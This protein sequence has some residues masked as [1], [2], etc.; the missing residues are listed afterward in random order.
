MNKTLSKPCIGKVRRQPIKNVEKELVRWS[1]LFG[2]DDFGVLCKP[3]VSGI[4]FPK[5][6]EE[7]RSKIGRCPIENGAIL[8]RGFNISGP[9]CF[10]RCVTAMSGGA[11]EYKFRASPRTQIQ[12][13][14]NIYTSTDY[15]EDESIFP[16]NEHSYSPVFPRLIFLYCETPALTGGE[17]PIGSTQ[18]LADHIHP[19]I[20]ETLTK[21]NIMY[22]RNYGDGFGL[23]WQRVF[24]THDRA[25]VEA[26]CQTV[27][28]DVEW[29]TGDRLRTRQIGPAMLRHPKTG[30]SV[31]FNHGTFFN[32]LTLPASVRDQLRS[33]YAPEDLPQNTFYG[34]GTPI[35]KVTIEHLQEAYQQVMRE[36]TWQTGDILM[37]DNLLSLH[38][39]TPF[40]GERRVMVAMAEPCR[41]QDLRIDL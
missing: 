25:E 28:I 20:R 12:S 37:L 39:R 5:W 33:E 3:N 21:K 11:V 29:K 7:N 31:W 18:H 6:A 13:G 41:S 19:D 23:P 34:D 16:H 40:T 22:V 24:Q 27:G 1:S 8:F 14:L 36:F 35:E 26:Y 17:T 4:S 10:D 38:A 30:E 2:I 9:K 32:E 15:P